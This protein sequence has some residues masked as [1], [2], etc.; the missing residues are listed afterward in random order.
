MK[1]REGEEGEKAGEG[2]EVRQIKQPTT[3]WAGMTDW[4]EAVRRKAPLG[5]EQE[6]RQRRST[7]PSGPE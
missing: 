1:E 6:E 2:E 7:G 4:V 3:E 5:R